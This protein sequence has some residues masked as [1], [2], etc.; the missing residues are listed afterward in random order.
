MPPRR[1]R[2]Y[3]ECTAIEKMRIAAGWTQAEFAGQARISVRTLQRI[4]SG[5]MDNPPI[6]YL[7]NIAIALGCELDDVIEPAWREFRD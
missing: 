1:R 5:E 2:Y 3:S 6:R 4:E 7:T